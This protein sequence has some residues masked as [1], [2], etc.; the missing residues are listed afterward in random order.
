LPL[1]EDEE[2]DD[3]AETE[4]DENEAETDELLDMVLSAGIDNVAA[5]R[6]ANP[7]ST[8]QYFGELILD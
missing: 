6:Q 5:I 4:L 7:K 2:T 1:S 3:E 8:K